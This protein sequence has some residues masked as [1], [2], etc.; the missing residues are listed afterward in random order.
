MEN[1]EKETT[2]WAEEQ[3]KKWLEDEEIKEKLNLKGASY[4]FRRALSRKEVWL[5]QSRK[6]QGDKQ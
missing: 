1:E 2:T 6:K 5:K 3:A 4:T